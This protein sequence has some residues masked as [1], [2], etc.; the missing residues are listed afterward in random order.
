MTTATRSLRGSAMPG[1]RRDGRK[2]WGVL[3]RRHV[4]EDL[5]GSAAIRTGVSL[6]MGAAAVSAACL[7]DPVRRPIHFLLVPSWPA[8]NSTCLPTSSATPRT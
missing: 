4:R 1:H 8:S 5:C 7:P 2:E 6:M 3:T